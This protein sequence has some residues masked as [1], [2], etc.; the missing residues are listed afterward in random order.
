MKQELQGLHQLLINRTMTQIASY[1]VHSPY[2]SV[3]L[4]YVPAALYLEVQFVSDQDS[5]IFSKRTFRR[6]TKDLNNLRVLMYDRTMG[7]WLSFSLS[8]RYDGTF[9][10]NFNYENEPLSIDGSVFD[11]E[12]FVKDLYLFP[13]VEEYIPQWINFPN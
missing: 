6:I 10:A 2:E 9:T 13:R 8:I 7:T 1:A 4:S 12:L 3:V 11:T 5:D